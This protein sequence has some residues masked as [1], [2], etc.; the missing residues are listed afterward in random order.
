MQLYNSCTQKC[1]ARKLRNDLLSPLWVLM[2]L[3]F[4]LTLYMLLPLLWPSGQHDLSMQCQCI[5]IK[6]ESRWKEEGQDPKLVSI[7]TPQ[8]R[9]KTKIF[10]PKWNAIT[11]MWQ[12]CNQNISLI[13]VEKKIVNLNGLVAYIKASISKKKTKLLWKPSKWLFW[14]LEFHLKF[15]NL[16]FWN[17]LKF[18]HMAAF[19]LQIYIFSFKS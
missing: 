12:W 13:V 10:N 19:E 17:I 5:R 9:F 18:V 2:T 7:T 4:Y 15:G 11:I 16:Q 3:L 8:W 14:N 1:E 6:Y